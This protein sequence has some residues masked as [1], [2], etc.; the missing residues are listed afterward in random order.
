MFPV[1]PQAS[2]WHLLISS[3]LFAALQDLKTLTP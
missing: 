1:R 3:A 2:V